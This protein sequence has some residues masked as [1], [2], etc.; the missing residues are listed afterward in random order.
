[1]SS[2]ASLP[3]NTNKPTM[4]LPI[5]NATVNPAIELIKAKYTANSGSK[6]NSG[7]NKINKA[8]MIEEKLSMY[9]MK[10][11]T[12]INVLNRKQVIKDV[13]VLDVNDG[14][15]NTLPE[16]TTLTDV[17]EIKNCEKSK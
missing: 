14:R 13:L 8:D 9:R 15:K 1:L 10:L 5:M 4:G 3:T 16:N 7:D 2:S 6:N 17:N 12:D 11:N